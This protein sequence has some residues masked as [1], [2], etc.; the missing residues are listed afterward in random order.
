M[1]RTDAC[2]ARP[3]AAAPPTAP[4]PEWLKAIRLR[5][6]HTDSFFVELLAF[7]PISQRDFLLWTPCQL[8]D[9]WYGLPSFRYLGLTTFRS[10]KTAAG[11]DY[12]AP[13]MMALANLLSH[14]TLEYATFIR[15]PQGDRTILRSAKDLGRVLAIA[16]LT[17]PAE[18]ATWPA[19]WRAAL[20]NR[21][22]KEH[23]AL[24]RRAGDG[25]RALLADRDALDQAR[26]S[27][28]LGLLTGLGIDVANLSA[29]AAQLFGLVLD[30]LARA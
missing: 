2:F 28:D 19:L 20:R 1:R 11:L 14:P 6:K 29:V 17:G 26:H 25:L 22:P 16:W 13:S 15:K 23:L 4:D 3:T 18:L 7:P 12:A 5:P 24:S 9:G 8:G 21:F 30:P 27:T 10:H